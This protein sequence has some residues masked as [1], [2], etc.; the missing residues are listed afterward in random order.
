MLVAAVA[1]VSILAW[2]GGGRGETIH[3]ATKPMTEQY[4]MG[5]YGKEWIIGGLGRFGYY[6]SI[7][8]INLGHYNPYVNGVA[9][10]ILFS[11]AILLW[12]FVFDLIIGEKKKYH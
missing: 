3:I 9:F 8:A 4:I 7:M 6:Y 1:A 5:D 12:A 10:L 11:A 2:Q